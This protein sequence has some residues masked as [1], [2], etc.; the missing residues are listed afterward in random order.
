MTLLEYEARLKRAGIESARSDVIALAVHVTGMS[1]ASVMARYR[2]ELKDSDAAALEAAV[3]R[4]EAR[5][6]IQYIIGKTEFFG[7]EYI[8]SPSCLIPRPETE[9][10]VDYG[11]S[12]LTKGDR[13][14]DLCCGSGCIGIA[15]CR[16]AGVTC[17]GVDISADAIGMA[18]ANARALGAEDKVTFHTADVT[19]GGGLDGGYAMI[20]SNPPY[21]VT[22]V[23]DTLE[24][25]LAYEPRIALDGGCDG[26]IF[27]RSIMDNYGKN[28]CDGGEFVFEIGYDQ[29]EAIVREAE[30]RE[31]SATVYNDYNSL[32]RMAVVKKISKINSESI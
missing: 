27:Y 26:M 20:F 15:L 16:H 10:L 14:A 24:P 11:K 1:N 25:E 22:D 23:V 7:D 19:K 3:R 21:I 2:D 17:D 32:P 4:R 6:P 31:Y 5:E 28:L 18:E 9:M 29:G 30:L 12:K 8:V 13:I